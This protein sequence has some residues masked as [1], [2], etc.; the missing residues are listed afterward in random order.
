A[1]RKGGKIEFIDVKDPKN[2]AAAHDYAQKLMT[3]AA[4]PDTLAQA[5]PM[6]RPIYDHVRAIADAAG[7]NTIVT[8]ES[9]AY[10]IGTIVKLFDSDLRIKRDI[11]DL[12]TS[13]RRAGESLA[14]DIQ[15]SR[16]LSTVPL[17]S[18]EVRTNPSLSRVLTSFDS[19]LIAF[20][21]PTT[22]EDFQDDM[23]GED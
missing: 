20:E 10:D 3:D 2:L 22:W 23:E 6:L 9:A 11:P 13:M 15:H 12:Q 21:A 18:P 1:Y 5:M 8:M 19:L 4:S 7:S 16:F 14:A 17:D